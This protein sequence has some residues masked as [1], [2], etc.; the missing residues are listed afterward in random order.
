MKVLRLY[1][2]KKQNKTKTSLCIFI[3]YL[4]F[5]FLKRMQERELVACWSPFFLLPLYYINYF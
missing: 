3:I 4:V 2:K 1:F 5:F